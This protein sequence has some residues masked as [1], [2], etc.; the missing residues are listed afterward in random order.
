MPRRSMALDLYTKED[1]LKDVYRK[2]KSSRSE[3]VADVSSN[4]FMLFCSHEGSNE[5][6]MASEYRKLLK[7]GEIKGIGQS[8]NKF[9]MFLEEDHPEIILN[10]H[11]APKPFK[12]KTPKTIR[13]YF[14]FVKSYLRKVHGIRLT[15]DDVKDYITFPTQLKEPRKAIPIEILKKLFDNASPTRR[16]LYYVLVSSGMR[17]GEA[18]ALTPKDFHFDENPVRITL[19]AEI[20]KTKES[21]ETYISSEAAEKIAILIESKPKDRKF[22]TDVDDI[23]KAVRTED[24]Y[25]DDLRK[26]LGLIEKYKYSNRNTVNIHGFRSYFHTAATHVYDSAYANA[27]DGHGAYLKTYY[28]LTPKQ[29]A[30]KYRKLEPYLLID[31]IKLETEKTKDKIIDDLQ[32]QMQKLQDKMTRLELLNK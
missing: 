1:W 28:S 27:L 5:A 11:A 22:L 10:Q 24:Q 14:G 21:R 18:L 29:R 13:T 12:G 17:I 19:D 30:E 7:N 16:A 25:F 8:L 23:P 6:E 32:L 26:R 15:I 9:I 4:M 20:T 2:S 31:S 3:R